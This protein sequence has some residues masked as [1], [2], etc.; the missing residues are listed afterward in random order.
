MEET[1]SKL[2]SG[3][4]D[5]AESA[6]WRLPLCFTKKRHTEEIKSV[7]AVVNSWR[8]KERMKT[9]SVALVMCLN[10]GVDPPDV[11]KVQP[12][13]RLECWIDPLMMVPQK[14]L[15]V[16]G[17]N[18]QKQ[19]E[20]W[21]PRARYKQSLDPTI[22]E[23]KKLCVSLRRNAKEERVLFHYNGHG[24]PKPT[25]NGEIWVFNRT[26]TQYIPLSIY[27]L[28]AWM[29]SPSIYVYDCSNAGMIIKL[30]SQFAEQHEKEDMHNATQS[31]LFESAEGSY[32]NCIQLGACQVDQT[33]PMHPDL[34]AD[35]FTSCLTT[36]IKMAARWFVMQN[37]SKH[38]SKLFL[39]LVDKIPG[40]LNDRRTMLGELNWVFT[41]I[42]DTIAWNILPRDTFQTLFRQDLL[43]ASLLRN[44][45]LAERIMR[46]YDCEP[47]SSPK[48]PAMHNHPM[49]Q[50]WDHILDLCL[51][52]LQRVQEHGDGFFVRTT[53][54]EEQLTA[55]E[56]W[57]DHTACL[58]TQQRS[59][60][61]QLPIVLQVLLSQAHRLRA[62][63]LL[64]RFLDLGPW[65]VNLTLSV[66]IFPYILKLLQSFAVELRPMLAFIWAKI[67]AVD[68]TC[69][70]DIVRENGFKY[71]F[72]LVEDIRLP[73]EQRMLGT[74]VLSRLMQNYKNGQ[75]L[76]LKN[77][78][79]CICLEQLA[80]ASAPY[81]QWLTLCLAQ[82]WS[83]YDKA[84]WV[85]VR[86]IA[87]EKL[88]IL[89]EDKI[90]E[91]RA[92]AV[93]ALGT[94]VSCDKDRTNY[95]IKV[96]LNIALTLLNTVA[97][98]MSPMVREEV[99]IA[100]QWT[101]I[102]FERYFLEI[103]MQE[104][105]EK[106]YGSLYKSPNGS[107]KTA[108]L[109]RIV[110]KEKILMQPTCPIVT[111]VSPQISPGPSISDEMQ[112][113]TKSDFLRRTNSS[114]SI[115][116]LDAYQTTSAYNN[117][118][119]KLW[120][121]LTALEHDI[122]PDVSATAQKL[123]K[124]IRQKL[125]NKPDSRASHSLPASPSS[126]SY[127]SQGDSPPLSVHEIRT[128]QRAPVS[129]SRS[130]SR[131]KK[132][133]PN[134]I[135]EE[136]AVLSS[137]S[138][139][140]N[141]ESD[142]EKDTTNMTKSLLRSQFFEWVSKNFAHPL[143]GM[144]DG[145]DFESA[146]YYERDWRYTRNMMLRKEAQ[147]EQNKVNNLNYKIEHQIFSSK[148][149]QSPNSLVFHPYEPHVIVATKDYL[150]VWDYQSSYKLCQWKPDVRSHN[151]DLSYR[152]TPHLSAVE[153]INSHDVALVLAGYNDGNI[154]VWSQIRDG[155]PKLISGWHALPI[156]KSPSF[157]SSSMAMQWDQRS[158]HLI[159][160]GDSRVIKIWDIETETKLTALST[161]VNASVTTMSM[162]SKENNIFAAGCKD[163]SIK[164]FD[165]RL[166][167]D[168]AKIA[169]FIGHHSK[170]LTLRLQDATVVS[171]SAY[172]DI[173]TFEFG[174]N[175]PQHE[176]HVNN[177]QSAAIHSMCN[178]IACSSINQMLLFYN[179][180]GQLLN[181]LKL[182][183]WFMSTR[184]SPLMTTKFHPQKVLLSTGAMDGTIALY[185]IDPKR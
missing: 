150:T 62:L 26:Y 112:E 113:E 171:A 81:K 4:A 88:Y 116:T 173:K 76:G 131:T 82:L 148:C 43:V 106:S 108:S 90:P 35:L 149:K 178:I 143:S 37:M 83:D 179:T 25:V 49:W 34:P 48:L 100:L 10:V 44:F 105:T 5:A 14:A 78:L 147:E 176:F 58:P 184:Y 166:P 127:L 133:V 39:D 109:S 24:V 59:A 2:S 28:Q 168:E 22:E 45:L 175:A 98:D 102:T 53:F 12:C 85:G 180:E 163:G 103:A 130:N 99:I 160:A 165:K 181:S 153:L 20:R 15:E 140:P 21:Q 182:T 117:N 84:R 80:N 156:C 110:S 64:G 63:D 124:Y 126:R 40:T 51:S 134:T 16:I 154:Q 162:Q 69:Q 72:Q 41:A 114:S 101:V 38:C 89:L 54:F 159:C 161:G 29:G 18:L 11:L 68:H 141:I 57:L 169:S 71:F 56:I 75:Q 104:Q 60:P 185:S 107:S 32:K 7:D 177:M 92:A 170:I 123:T 129:S 174:H 3:S 128:R 111:V 42:T 91:V 121:G 95:A 157:E 136:T 50:S 86:D 146:I 77:N 135:V 9:V 65:A 115:V 167:P 13:A 33:L 119:S 61:E 47:V 142:G 52:Q 158:C 87:H 145:G 70:T 120:K 155:P 125:K 74:V 23:V 30:F 36:P 73:E 79:V 122:F 151:L 152:L 139:P 97:K 96:D 137:S 55:F 67:M 132:I 94:Y 19:Y 118:H 164:V 183:D 31:P 138:S 93:F 66:G 172:G 8:L 6:D 1:S 46:T 27:D 17:I 144:N